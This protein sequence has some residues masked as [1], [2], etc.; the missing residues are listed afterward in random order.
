MIKTILGLLMVIA[1]VAASL[2]A[3]AFTL[4]NQDEM[5]HLFTILVK[6][7]EWRVTIEPNET[8]AH[9]CRAGCSI[10]LGYNKEQDFRGN[11]NVSIKDGQM[12]IAD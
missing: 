10:S 7:D 8:L 6:D 12:T 1:V 3:Q 9:L 11:E 2:P 5:A 4:T